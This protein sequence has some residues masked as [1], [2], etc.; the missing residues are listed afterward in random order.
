MCYL[1][2]GCCWLCSQ[3]PDVWLLWDAGTSLCAVVDNS[4][5]SLVAAFH[6][7]TLMTAGLFNFHYSE[8]FNLSAVSF[9]FVKIKCLSPY[10]DFYSLRAGAWILSEQTIISGQDH[11]QHKVLSSKSQSLL[12]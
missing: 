11:S 6:M 12:G 10:L 9:C 2:I 7:P 4:I 1:S 3:S 5:L 8:V